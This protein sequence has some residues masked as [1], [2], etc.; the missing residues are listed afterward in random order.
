MIH[1]SQSAIMHARAERLIHMLRF[2]YRRTECWSY[3]IISF[4]TGFSISCLNSA[5]VQVRV[6]YIASAGCWT[7][8]SSFHPFGLDSH[9]AGGIDSKFQADVVLQPAR[10]IREIRHNS[11]LSR[12]ANPRQDE[13]TWTSE[14]RTI[15]LR[16]T[17]YVSDSLI[18]HVWP[19]KF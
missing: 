2:I 10:S 14:L 7:R 19:E 12:E 8:I 11:V 13:A 3:N 17:L 4:P 9:L 6:G 1:S 5:S 15:T 18:T 16:L